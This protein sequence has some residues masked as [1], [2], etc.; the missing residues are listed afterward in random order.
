M[1][2]LL[3][4]QGKYLPLKLLTVQWGRLEAVERRIKILPS[5]FYYSPPIT[6]TL[7]YLSHPQTAYVG[8]L[9]VA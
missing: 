9:V 5:I 8:H 6:G 2:E 1:G 7:S 3:H 4:R